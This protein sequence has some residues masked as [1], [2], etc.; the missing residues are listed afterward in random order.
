M[1]CPDPLLFQVNLVFLVVLAYQKL[2]AGELALRCL[3]FVNIGQRTHHP[4]YVC[5][6]ER[7]VV[8]THQTIVAPLHTTV[9]DAAHPITLH[10]GD[11]DAHAESVLRIRASRATRPEHHKIYV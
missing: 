11:E 2:L 4:S 8:A 3:H 1:L 6:I 9:A 10:E 5:P 7:T